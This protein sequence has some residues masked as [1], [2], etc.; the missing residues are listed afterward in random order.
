VEKKE[1]REGEEG[2]RRKE[3]ERNRK[4]RGEKG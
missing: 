1:M 4:G 2:G 3:E